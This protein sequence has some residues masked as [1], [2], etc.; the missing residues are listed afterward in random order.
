MN[1][2][3]FDLGKYD[4]KVMMFD[5]EG[6]TIGKYKIGSLFE[7][8]IELPEDISGDIQLDR[9]Q[10]THPDKDGVI[11]TGDVFIDPVEEEW[12]VCIVKSFFD[13]FINDDPNEYNIVLLVPMGDYGKSKIKLVDAFRDQLSC[14]ISVFPQAAFITNSGLI[15]DIGGGTTDYIQFKNGKMIEAGSF[16][17][18]MKK[19][20]FDLRKKINQK[21]SIDLGVETMRELFINP[22]MEINNKLE[23]VSVLRNNILNTFWDLLKEQIITKKNSV[24]ANDIL[25][26]GGAVPLFKDLI[27]ESGFKCIL[28][29]YISII[30]TEKKIIKK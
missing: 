21:M 6:N 1:N 17:I 8:D 5:S 25:V 22:V 15:I 4:I 23:D 27:E 20:L 9:M 14:E 29:S 26:V 18:G 12:A 3:I 7:Y 13:R 10:S 11:G 16:H 24:H 28:D 30:S 19:A 2:V